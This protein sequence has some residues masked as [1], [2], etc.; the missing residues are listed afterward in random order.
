MSDNLILLPNGAPAKGLLRY[1][2]QIREKGQPI[3]LII[4]R[5]EVNRLVTSVQIRSRLQAKVTGYMQAEFPLKPFMSAMVAG[6]VDAE[7]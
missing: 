5:L 7:F 6:R 3:R 1:A 2:V 4:V